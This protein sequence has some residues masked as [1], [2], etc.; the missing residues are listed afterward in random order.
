MAIG[1]WLK[2]TRMTFGN[3]GAMANSDHLIGALVVTFAIIAWAE[4][5]HAVCFVNVLFGASL[6][7]AP[8]PIALS[9]PRGRVE[10]P[11]AGWDPYIV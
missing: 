9:I 5:A 1:I 11:Y 4:I 10:N 6:I 7:A 8:W 2:F 3:A